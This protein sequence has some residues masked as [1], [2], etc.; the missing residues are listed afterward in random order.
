MEKF[1]ILNS[2]ETRMKY[3]QQLHPRIQSDSSEKK[4]R[5]SSFKGFV[6]RRIIIKRSNVEIGS[7]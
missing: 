7:Y 3:S 6:T 4:I 2:D 5:S 1:Q